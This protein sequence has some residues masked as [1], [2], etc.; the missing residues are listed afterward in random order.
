MATTDVEDEG[1][2]TAVPLAVRDRG[3]RRRGEVMHS[4]LKPHGSEGSAP[5]LEVPSLQAQEAVTALSSTPSLALP[6]SASC[7]RKDHVSARGESLP[8]SFG[9]T[10]DAT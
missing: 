6:G 7:H 4:V 2:K 9:E 10:V 3:A 5:S 8:S 1:V